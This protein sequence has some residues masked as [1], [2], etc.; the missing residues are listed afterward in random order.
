MRLGDVLRKWR[1]LSDTGIREAAKQI[2]ISAPTLSRIERGE[3]MD[4]AVLAKVL[5][6]LLG[7]A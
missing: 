4:G 5:V 3:N 7:A 1:R 6:W 2:G